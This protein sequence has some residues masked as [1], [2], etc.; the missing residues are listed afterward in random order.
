MAQVV[1]D[2][3][4]ELQQLLHVAKEQA[5][6]LTM[7]V[8]LTMTILIHTMPDV[9]YTDSAPC[10]RGVGD[11]EGDP[12]HNY[13]HNPNSNQAAVEETARLEAGLEQANP[14]HI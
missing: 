6:I 1:G 13:N 7:T 4:R 14:L 9:Q 12:N 8:P 2:R 3:M 5:A 10:R 11:R